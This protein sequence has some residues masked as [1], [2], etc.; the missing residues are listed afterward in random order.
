MLMSRPP[1]WWVGVTMVSLLQGWPTSE[2]M[3]GCRDQ[4]SFARL[5]PVVLCA[6]QAY[7]VGANSTEQAEACQDIRD[8][9]HSPEGTLIP[10]CL[11]SDK[12]LSGDYRQLGLCEVNL[13]VKLHMIAVQ[14]SLHVSVNSVLHVFA[15]LERD[16]FV[17]Y[18]C[19]AYRNR[20]LLLKLAILQQCFGN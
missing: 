15:K 12:S 16:I 5:T 10:F 6:L 3:Q 13:Q 9:L 4:R 1:L 14:T 17:C 18:V 8:Q 2:Y 7:A 11:V 20:L 19:V